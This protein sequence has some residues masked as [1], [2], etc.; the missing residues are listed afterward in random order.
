MWALA[1]HRAGWQTIDG[2]DVVQVSID[3]A[4]HNRIT[5]I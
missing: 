1:N 2:S 5:S 3:R 4:H